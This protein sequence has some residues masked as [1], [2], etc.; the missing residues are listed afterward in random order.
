MYFKISVNFFFLT[1]YLRGQLFGQL[2]FFMNSPTQNN[3]PLAAGISTE[4]RRSPQPHFV[5]TFIGKWSTCL[6]RWFVLFRLVGALYFLRR[7]L[8]I[9]CL[10]VDHFRRCSHLADAHLWPPVYPLAAS[11]ALIS[12]KTSV[13]IY[14]WRG[15][16]CAGIGGRWRR[17]VDYEAAVWLD[18]SGR[19]HYSARDAERSR[20]RQRQC[21][22]VS[23]TIGAMCLWRH[24]ILYWRGAA[25]IASG[26]VRRYS[27]THPKN[28][29]E[30]PS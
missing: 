30:E 9:S 20:R 12:F 17:R 19:A 23:F 4:P 28:C 10:A 3:P 22:S 7:C 26:D 8:S 1:R 2:F 24:S 25:V 11:P 21:V 29:Y 5:R 13:D 27:S 18:L 15:F 16:C 6:V 14:R